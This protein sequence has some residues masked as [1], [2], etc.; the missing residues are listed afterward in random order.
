VHSNA[1]GLS[2]LPPKT[3]ERAANEVV[4]PLNVFNMMQFEPSTVEDAKGEA[5]RKPV[6]SQAHEVVTKGWL[7]NHV[8]VL[9]PFYLPTNFV[10]RY[11]RNSIK[12][13]WEL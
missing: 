5:Q 11:L 4:D 10:H 6:L 3:E 8:P 2:R 7:S 13:I 9:D 12:D 1:D